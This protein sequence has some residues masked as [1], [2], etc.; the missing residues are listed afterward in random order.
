MS[1]TNK[2]F[3][4]DEARVIGKEIGNSREWWS[5]GESSSPSP[6]RLLPERSLL[7]CV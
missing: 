7:A 3:T 4:A 1:E 5:R 2:S 6:R